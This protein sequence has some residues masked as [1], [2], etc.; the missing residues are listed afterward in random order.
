M[1]KSGGVI[2]LG[3]GALLAL[4]LAACQPV[5]RQG[6]GAGVLVSAS[7]R[8]LSALPEPKAAKTLRAYFVNVGN[9]M[10]HV[11]QCP[12]ASIAIVDDCGSRND[13]GALGLA[14]TTALVRNLTKGREVRVIATHKDADHSNYLPTIFD[15]PGSA[16]VTTV[17]AGGSYNK[18]S[19]AMQQWFVAAN[20]DGAA[21]RVNDAPTAFK[22][23]DFTNG[24]HNDGNPVPALACGAAST[25]VLTVDTDDNANGSS[26]VVMLEYGG[27]KLIL[28]GDATA[29]TEA[30]AIANFKGTAS[31][32]FLNATVLETSHHGA[33]SATSPTSNTTKWAEATVPYYLVSS[34]GWHGSY[35][36]PRCA[37]LDRYAAAKGSRLLTSSDKHTLW[38]GT[39][40]S[41]WEER[42]SNPTS[43]ST[44]S[45]EMLVVD[46]TAPGSKAPRTTLY[47]ET[48]K[49]GGPP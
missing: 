17:W 10:C 29:D 6:G 45:N 18:Y 7:T 46:I 11:V 12:D 19:G 13:G 4:A 33:G 21:V 38:C 42:S 5:V 9:G 41:S 23:T 22:S 8:P 28:P 35:G 31:G 34:A 47:Y 30:Q 32:A 24:W 48:T 15:A 44:S 20:R 49:S 16:K 43:Y 26:M 37:A 36:H 25:Y 39:D 3:G 14:Q 40:H 27:E 1:V 2:R